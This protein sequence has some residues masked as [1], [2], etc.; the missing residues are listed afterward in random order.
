MY[1]EEMI[2]VLGKAI[3]SSKNRDF[4][5]LNDPALVPLYVIGYLEYA[6]ITLTYDAE[7]HERMHNELE[8]RVNE[9]M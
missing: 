4:D 3:E 7:L 8:E 2:A 5:C 9:L 6:G 1:R